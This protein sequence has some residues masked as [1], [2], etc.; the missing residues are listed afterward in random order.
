MKVKTRADH[1]FRTLLAASV[2]AA[3]LA[4]LAGC[5]DD[6]DDAPAPAADEASSDLTVIQPGRPGEGNSTGTPGELPSTPPSEA[7]IA[8]VQMMVPHHAQAIEMARLA[9]KHAADPAV[10]RLA[11]RI[12]AAQGPEIVA[13]SSWL[14]R[15]GVQVPQP[16]DDPM[17]YDHGSHGHDPMMG[18][19]TE[20]QMAQLAQARGARFDRLFLEGMIQHHQGAVDM[21]DNLAEEG[22]DTIVTEMAGDI[23]LTQTAEIARMRDLLAGL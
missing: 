22:V 4:G 20:A 5:S 11:E 17:E 9:R 13:M 16:G 14:E 10:R 1:T 23:H 6:S 12:R 18:M 2:A 19:L 3:A 15:V 8:F 21:A 7:D